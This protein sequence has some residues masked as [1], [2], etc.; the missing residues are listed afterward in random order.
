[1]NTFKAE[2]FSPYTSLKTTSAVKWWLLTGFGA[3]LG[4]VVAVL[5]FFITEN[6]QLLA[7]LTALCFPIAPLISGIV[8]LVRDVQFEKLRRQTL[9]TTLNT[10]GW[11]SGLYPAMK[12]WPVVPSSL[13]HNLEPGG[14]QAPVVAHV[15]GKLQSQPAEMI[16]LDARYFTSDG[17]SAFAYIHVALQDSYPHTIVDG[18]DGILRSDLVAKVGNVEKVLLEGTLANQFH[19]YTVKGVGQDSLY[20][21]TP[22]ILAHILDYGTDFNVEIISNSMYVLASP[23]HLQDPQKFANFMNLALYLTKQFGIRAKARGIKDG[24]FRHNPTYAQTRMDVSIS[25][26]DPKDRRRL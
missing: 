12:D 26:I 3:T 22:D 23:D 11:S 14:I 9:V 16:F 24:E 18:H 25:F 7:V 21:L 17:K 15:Q 1:M 19:V 2:D 4:I 6:E 13:L 10:L 20:T 8:W 5:L